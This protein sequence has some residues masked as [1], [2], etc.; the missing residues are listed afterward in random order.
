ML[1]QNMQRRRRVTTQNK[2]I[3]KEHKNFVD[4]YASHLPVGSSESHSIR[5]PGRR[6][7]SQA[8]ISSARR[9]LVK[10]SGLEA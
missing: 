3:L 10:L 9:D 6:T 8:N 7:A 4:S 1:K 2:A 5:S